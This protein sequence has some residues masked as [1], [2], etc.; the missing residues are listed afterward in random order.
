M[1]TN[2]ICRICGESNNSEVYTVREM[3]FG[4]R[5]EFLYF[6]CCRCECL[7]IAEFPENISDYYPTN[8]YSLED[9]RRIK[10]Q[11]SGLKSV[12]KK[13]S[14]Q[15]NIFPGSLKN[16]ILRL[17]FPTEKYKILSKL[18]IDKNTRILDVGCGSGAGFLYPLAEMGFR[19]AMGCDPYL[20][21]SIEYENG[22]QIRKTDI[23]DIEGTWDVI[24]YHHSFEHI[25]NPIENLEKINKLLS[26]NGVCIIRIP[27][28]SCYA[29][30]TYKADWF[31]ID[32]PR[33]YFLH[34]TKSMEYMLEKTGLELT[35]VRH[36]STYR[37]LMISEQY[38]KDIPLVNSRK[39]SLKESLSD[40][41]KK[42]KYRNLT[43][44]L[45]KT[46]QGDQAAFF[47]RKKTSLRS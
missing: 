45:N 33:H 42:I 15:T 30:E 37:Q 9:E 17:V 13:L 8:Y 5:D 39:K 26:A 36:D 44:K 43:R 38:A 22:L 40:R 28:V 4:K 19:H 23:F 31:Q 41:W 35:G 12:I 46:G 20:S 11:F 29:W 47:I 1:T 3:M 7:Q 10:A 6:Q 32:A 27:T 2:Y 16:K 21:R 24:T 25:A 34:S 14:Y 18:N